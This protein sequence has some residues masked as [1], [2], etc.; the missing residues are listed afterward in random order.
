MVVALTRSMHDSSK[1]RVNE[2]VRCGR[3]ES[4]SSTVVRDH[5]ELQVA[6]TSQA[7]QVVPT[8]RLPADSRHRAQRVKTPAWSRIGVGVY[9][10]TY[11]GTS[12][13]EVCSG[14]DCTRPCIIY[15][16][17]IKREI[18]ANR[19][20][21]GAIAGHIAP[22]NIRHPATQFQPSHTD[23]R[24]T[25]FSKGRSLFSNVYPNQASQWLAPQLSSHLLP[26]R[27]I[28]QPVAQIWPRALSLLPRCHSSTSGFS[29]CAL[30]SRRPSTTV[31]TRAAWLG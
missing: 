30:R 2:E 31:G 21:E 17:G 4:R 19:T 16:S 27:Y 11:Q 22:A 8:V 13:C 24:S 3:L 12:V 1:V 29:D 9:D 5:R 6:L 18:L 23:F 7:T 14:D 26:F 25:K 10:F 20:T 28:P 15:V